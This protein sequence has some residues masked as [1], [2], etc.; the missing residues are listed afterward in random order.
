[1]E[2]S[3]G[4]AAEKARLRERF[5]AARLAMPPQ[6]RAAASEAICA[7]VLA[8][9]EIAALGTGAA[10]GVFWPRVDRAEVGAAIHIARALRARAV[11]TAYPRVTGDGTMAWHLATGA[12]DLL[13]GRWGL[14][15]PA[16]AAPAVGVA[17]L[18]V[19]LVPG[20]AFGRDG[21]RLGWGGGFYDRAL[22]ETDALAVGLTF[23]VALTGRLPA[24]A[25]DARLDVV[26]TER[27]TARA[28]NPAAGGP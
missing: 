10:A 28:R 14:R 24:G 15:E 13:P 27:G 6:A 5:Q 7:H 2:R 21:S 11:Q 9:P 20:L 22:G 26:V 16:A 17:E 3:E 23:A 12:A 1:M 8:L 19:V 4:I 25:H 18:A